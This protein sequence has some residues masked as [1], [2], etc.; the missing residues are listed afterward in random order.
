MS[1]L[2]EWPYVLFTLGLVF[3]YFAFNICFPVRSALEDYFLVDEK[4]PNRPTRK[5][6]AKLVITCF[7]L[8]FPLVLVLGIKEFVPWFRDLIKEAV[9]QKEV[10]R[11]RYLETAS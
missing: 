1:I 10:W 3:S 4:S 5:K 6:V 2:F 11:C 7:F 8:G 9:I